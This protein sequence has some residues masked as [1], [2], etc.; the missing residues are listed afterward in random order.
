MNV[1][2]LPQADWASFLDEFGRD[3]RG[4]LATVEHQHGRD[5]PP[6]IHQRPL[7]ALTLAGDA[8]ARRVTI[9]LH[10][11]NSSP[12]IQIERPAVIRVHHTD[13][14]APQHVEIESATGERLMLRLRGVR[15]PDTLFDGVAPGELL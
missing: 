9:V 11:E 2:E 10:D 1:R 6:Q 8:R 13:E 3:H 5:T 7:L 4:W 12:T 14:G 15:S